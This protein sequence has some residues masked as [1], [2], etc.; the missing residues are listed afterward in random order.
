MVRTSGHNKWKNI[1]LYIAPEIKKIELDGVL[2]QN[3]TSSKDWVYNKSKTKYQL[4]LNMHQLSQIFGEYNIVKN[5]KP[6]YGQFYVLSLNKMK[7]IYLSNKNSTKNLKIHWCI[8]K[9]TVE[10]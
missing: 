6:Q 1:D 5:I 8:H 4:T 10:W 7:I 9:Q 2:K 3:N